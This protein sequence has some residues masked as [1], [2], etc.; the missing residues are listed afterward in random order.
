MLVHRLRMREQANPSRSASEPSTHRKAG[1][2]SLAPEPA[3]SAPLVPTVPGPEEPTVDAQ[4][5]QIRSYREQITQSLRREDALH[6]ELEQLRKQFSAQA[7]RESEI[8]RLKSQLAAWHDREFQLQA[9]LDELRGRLVAAKSTAAAAE[10]EQETLRKAKERAEAKL[11]R[12]ITELEEQA[13]RHER[14]IR[15]LEEW[16]EIVENAQSREREIGAVLDEAEK[17][18]RELLTLRAQESA[19]DSELTALQ[20]ALHA[21]EAESK[22]LKNQLERE[23]KEAKKRAATEAATAKEQNTLREREHQLSSRLEHTERVE[24]RCNQLQAE[25]AAL[26]TEVIDLRSALESEQQRAAA[27]KEAEMLFSRQ[28]HSLRVAEA[29]VHSGR[30]NVENLEGEIAKLRRDA[31]A[32]DEELQELRTLAE[33]HRLQ[34]AK[35]EEFDKRFAQQAHALRV[36]DSSLASRR[37][38]V[39]R[40]ETLLD[41]ANRT[42]SRLQ[43]AAPQAVPAESSAH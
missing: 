38:T 8:A 4:S 17:N 1:S 25:V 5:A 11:A 22:D 15:Q 35:W 34:A 29:A 27:H 41:E 37:Q 26:N 32:R 16:E 14:A 23:W 28:A 42:I 20:T 31:A 39:E 7:D 36:A 24:Q 12:L 33:Q 3:H 40:L 9:S 6:L 2:I 21:R 10:L 19:R 30:R 18:R 43:S 13:I